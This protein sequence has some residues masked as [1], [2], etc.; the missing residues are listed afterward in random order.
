[1]L[2]LPL[3][4]DGE[5]QTGIHLNEERWLVDTL[6]TSGAGRKPEAG[7]VEAHCTGGSER[8][9][10]LDAANVVLHPACLPSNWSLWSTLATLS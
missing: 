4:Q 5:Y 10:V 3:E 6:P 2:E 8:T 7:T 9:A 1:M